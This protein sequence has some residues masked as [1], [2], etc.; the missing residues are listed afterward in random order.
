MHRIISWKRTFRGTFNLI[1]V[2]TWALKKYPNQLSTNLAH[3]IKLAKRGF[4]SL[5]STRIPVPNVI[6]P[7]TRA[8]F[9]KPQA[10]KRLA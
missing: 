9:P 1:A 4:P 8:Q 3:Q 10:G 7:P 6:L 5:Q 2:V